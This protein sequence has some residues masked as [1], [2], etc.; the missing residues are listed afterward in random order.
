M[1]IILITFTWITL[2]HRCSEKGKIIYSTKDIKIAKNK[3]DEMVKNEIEFNNPQPSDML[4]NQ[5]PNPKS[6]R[7]SQKISNSLKKNLRRKRYNIAMKSKP[8]V[9]PEISELPEEEP[10]DNINSTSN[11]IDEKEIDVTEDVMKIITLNAIFSTPSEDMTLDP[12]EVK[13]IIETNKTE[14]QQIKNNPEQDNLG[15]NTEVENNG[16]P[17]PFMQQVKQRIR[18]LEEAEVE[19]NSPPPTST[20]QIKQ[21]ELLDTEQHKAINY[22][23]HTKQARE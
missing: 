8:T 10:E 20:K 23:M 18:Q 22:K 19:H 1:I 13:P 11:T 6:R 9:E 5:P 12:T 21:L 2:N 17:L 14:T 16:L 3:L 15:K 4:T 7:S